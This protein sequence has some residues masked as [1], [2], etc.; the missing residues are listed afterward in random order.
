MTEL[1]PWIAAPAADVDLD[2]P[3]AARFGRIPASLLP[4]ARELVGSI[5]SHAP[6]EALALVRELGEGATLATFAE[7]IDAL[8]AQTGMHAVDLWLA[9][10]SYDLTVA[11]FGCSTAAIRA[12]DG[13]ILARNMDWWPE[14]PLA[15][16][17]C[18]LRYLQN[19]EPQFEVAGWPGGVGVVTGLSHRGGGFAIALNAVGGS[20]QSRLDGFPVLLFLRHVIEYADGFDHALDLLSH[21]ALMSPALFTLVGGSREVDQRI[22][23]ERSPTR[24]A[25]RRPQGD[26]AL[27]TT[28]DY[29]ALFDGAH[30]GDAL[31]D[32]ACSRFD[33]LRARCAAWPQ[34]GRS[35]RDEDLLLALTDPNVQMEITCQHVL[36]RPGRA[37]RHETLRVYTPRHLAA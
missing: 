33:A 12:A 15:R 24:C 32:S 23:I 31:G 28:N 21:E 17:S 29:R 25:L 14:G 22:V 3:L 16:S 30:A 6:P 11:T 26:A 36:M 19:G 34:D 2:R 37:N 1:C 4:H 5:R 8:A 20:E 13:P 18:H 9:N 27:I 35:I 7:E 10:G